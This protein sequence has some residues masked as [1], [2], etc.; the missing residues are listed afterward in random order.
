MIISLLAVIA[1]GILAWMGSMMGF[2]YVLAV[3]LPYTAI[4]VFLVGFAWRIIDWAKRPVPFCIPTT[5][6][7]QKSLPWIKPATLDNPSDKKGVW[8][9]MILEVLLFRSL[10]RNTNVSI[11]GDRVVYWSSKFLWLFALIFHYS[12]LIIFIRHF[13]FFAE[14]V[15]FFVNA[16]EL[17]DGILQIGAPRLFMTGPLIL[18][19]LAYLIGRRFFNQKVRY[20]S[21]MSDYFPLFLIFGLCATGVAMRYF[22]KVDIANVKVFVISLLHFAPDKVALA[23]IGSIFYV[24]MFFLTVLLMY[25]P[26]SKLMHAAG[27]FFSPTRN[28]AND[29]RMKLHVNPWNPEKVYRTYAEYED[30]FRAPMVEAGLP[31]EKPLEDKE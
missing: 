8:G 2:Q 20:I 27:V 21:L 26:F 23:Q 29:S 31:V 5:G 7:Q 28:L 9:R 4:T 3:C 12:F 18:I 30:E 10:F 16:I 1:L 17:I 24:H 25:F 15:P 11:E 19:A 22:M 14:P 6:G 13:R